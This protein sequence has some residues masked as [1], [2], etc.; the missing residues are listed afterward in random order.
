VSRTNSEYYVKSIR[1]QRKKEAA[2]VQA[3][4][5]EGRPGKILLS[6]P[7]GEYRHGKKCLVPAC[8]MASM[9]HEP[10]CRDC[11]LA[12]P[13]ELRREVVAATNA[14]RC[15]KDID[16]AKHR[17]A[18]AVMACVKALTEVKTDETKR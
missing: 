16:A 18:N 3:G 12:L 14:A 15:T 6:L 13:V 10:F 5:Y 7:E 9:P 4:K 8:P 2:A 17:W 11:W 1:A